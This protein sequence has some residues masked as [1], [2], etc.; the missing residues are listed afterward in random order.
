MS[1]KLIFFDF[2][3]EAGAPN[4]PCAINA[5]QIVYMYTTQSTKTA[6]VFTNGDTMIA[7]QTLASFKSGEQS[8]GLG[9]FVSIGTPD[10]C[11]KALWGSS[12]GEVLVNT[13]YL[14]QVLLSPE[15]KTL[16]QLNQPSSSPVSF[17]T[18]RIIN[19]I[20]NDSKINESPF[21]YISLDVTQTSTSAPVINSVYSNVGLTTTQVTGSRSASGTYALAFPTG[22]PI[23][24][25][26]SFFV[27]SPT[28]ATNNPIVKISATSATGLGI[29]TQS[30]GFANADG[31]LSNTKIDILSWPTISVPSSVVQVGS[32]MQGGIVFHIDSSTRKAYVLYEGIINTGIVWCTPT[33][34]SVTG[35]GVVTAP[36]SL[37]ISQSAA[38]TALIVAAATGTG[39]A[40]EADAFSATVDGVTYSDW[41]L[42]SEDAHSAIYNNLLYSQG[43]P[44]ELKNFIP[45]NTSVWSSN[46]QLVASSRLFTFSIPT[47]TFSATS[48]STSNNVL[49]VREFSF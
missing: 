1:A 3:T 36:E 49:A 23:G 42:P 18:Q 2:V 43:D 31:I 35:V 30:S 44:F 12:R 11:N 40:A 14:S 20:V 28:G 7:N 34:T 29:V 45:L 4:S 17:I 25:S 6:V 37:A 46:Q 38:N 10:S 26:P 39:A 48:K 5:S 41:A 8:Q 13:T 27:S 9:E 47:P 33:G 19:Q 22:T 32:R 16:V 24:A 21:N 15:Y